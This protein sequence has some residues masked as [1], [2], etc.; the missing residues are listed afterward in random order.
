[1][2]AHA[3]RTHDRL[4][5]VAPRTVAIVGKYAHH[6]LDEVI[7]GYGD[8][9]VVFVES[10]AHAFSKIK[11]ARPDLV[12]LCVTDDDADGCRVLSMLALDRET[13]RIPVLT[14]LL[15]TTLRHVGEAETLPS[16]YSCLA[17]SAMN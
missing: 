16:T 10:I 2:L 3:E 13:S 9:D 4:T 8:F 6:Y 14:H 12:V 17:S 5:A 7:E 1:M 11:R 15:P